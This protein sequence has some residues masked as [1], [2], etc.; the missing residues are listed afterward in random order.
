MTARTRT[1]RS[2]GRP[3]RIDLDAIADAALELAS[4]GVDALTVQRVADKLGVQRS[5]I[6]HYL[7]SRDA[8]LRA[9]AERLVESI[10][11]PEPG[12][13]W[14]GYLRAC[15]AVTTEA[16][17]RYPGVM[18]II[19]NNLW[20]LPDRLMASAM[21]LIDNLTAF[22][23]PPDLAAASAD[24]IVNFAVDE[25][26]RVERIQRVAAGG[27]GYTDGIVSMDSGTTEVRQ[28]MEAHYDAGPAF[29]VDTKV[30][31]LLDGIEARL[32]RRAQSS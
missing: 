20:P 16:C 6:Y 28:A 25:T 7:D 24:L 19:Y 4:E 13:D 3:N 8:L 10:V 14:R 26:R 2:R 30:G 1:S 27:A 15:F 22:G 11:W 12:E 17:E 5:A 9:L 21:R 29:W 23:F 32:L 31:I 18:E